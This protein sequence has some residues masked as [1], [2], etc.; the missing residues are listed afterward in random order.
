MTW[1]TVST[2]WEFRWNLL[3]GQSIQ[4]RD[5]EKI[6]PETAQELEGGL[7]SRQKT[8]ICLGIGR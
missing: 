2:V 4:L 1:E 7:L 6:I 8:M 5:G 3:G